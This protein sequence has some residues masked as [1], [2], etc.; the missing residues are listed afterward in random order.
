MMDFMRPIKN[1]QPKLFSSIC[2]HYIAAEESE[3]S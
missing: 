2:R 1:K 3:D